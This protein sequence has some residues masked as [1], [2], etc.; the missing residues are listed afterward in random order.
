MSLKKRFIQVG[1]GLA[2]AGLFTV[3][4]TNDVDAA[5]WQ[6]STVSEIEAEINSQASEQDGAV[7]YTFK[8]GD[9]L[10]GISE[11]T[12]I[13]VDK[14]AQVNDI[15]DS[16]GLVVG[17]S[18]YLSKDKSV[19]SVEDE[20]NEVKSYDV[21]EEEVKQ[22]ETPEPVKEEKAE[23]D[24]QSSDK[25]AEQEAAAAEEAEADRQAE[26]E[27]AAAEEAEADRQ[28][29]QEAAAAEQAEAD[30]Q[31]EQEAAAAEQAEREE[32]AS[33]EATPSS[34]VTGSEA[35]AKEE[36]AQRES[37]GDYGAVNPTGKYIGRYQLTNSYLNG[38][39]SPANQERVADNYVAERYGS[40][41][42]ALEFWNAN[43]WY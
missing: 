5:E 32:E 30:R 9:T 38:D 17:N 24:S 18:I 43:G 35:A 8:P 29:E 25:Q 26:Q 4:N 39:H 20:N 13:S 42:N 12:D 27:A 41:T 10:W 7:E 34:S 28:A 14:L 6:A 23:K 36:I 15:E 16:R 21:S 3:A 31:A 19:V 37:G 1:S 2:L 40:W 33:Q 11:A 22:T